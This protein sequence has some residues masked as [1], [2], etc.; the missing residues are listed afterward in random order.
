MRRIIF[1]SLMLMLFGT[2]A[3]AQDC[4]DF[5]RFVDFGL[6]APDGTM[7]RGGA[8]YRAEGFDGQALL[9]RELTIC[10]DV[11]NLAVDGRGNPIPVVT[12]VNYSPQQTGIDLLEL[13]LA[14]VDDI[15]SETERNASAHRARLDQPDVVTTQGLDYLCASLKRA[16]TFSCQFVSPFG[17]NLALV[18]YCTPSECR[19]PVLAVKDNI[20][21]AA[22]WRPSGAA[23]GDPKTWA[24]EIGDKVQ[25][26][27][28]FLA[29]LS[30]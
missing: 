13:R 5:F 20:A 4:P 2:Q 7:H 21:V 25:Q 9:I 28:D 24:S 30:S 26:V 11:R 1:T 6:E 17:G 3:R 23:I 19:M 16:D 22:S 27:H 18:V 29:P 10:R 12:S 14:A 8:T 15:A